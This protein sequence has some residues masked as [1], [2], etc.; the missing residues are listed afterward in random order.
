[1][2]MRP[3]THRAGRRHIVENRHRAP[4]SERVGSNSADGVDLSV[5]ELDGGV[6]AT[7]DAQASNLRYRA[8]I[9]R[10]IERIR[11]TAALDRRE[12]R[13]CRRRAG[14]SR[15]FSPP[16]IVNAPVVPTASMIVR[17]A[18]SAAL[19]P[20]PDDRGRTV[21]RDIER[22]GSLRAKGAQSD[23]VECVCTGRVHVPGGEAAGRRPD[24][25][26]MKVEV[27]SWCWCRRGIAN[28]IRRSH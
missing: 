25:A 11:S 28:R 19:A 8:G 9:R 16:V 24:P 5:A 27:T 22:R 26:S 13:R 3:P 1:M 23:V 15:Q 17:F 10:Q 12:R 14:R 2:L 7:K 4:S 20:R 21:V 6:R 18:Q